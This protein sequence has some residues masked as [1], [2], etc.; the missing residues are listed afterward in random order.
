[1]RENTESG[2]APA[3]KELSADKALLAVLTA[4][5]G[6]PKLSDVVRTISDL[7]STVVIDSFNLSRSQ[8]ATIVTLAGVAPTREDFIMFKSRLEPLLALGTAINYPISDE[9]KTSNVSFSLSFQV[10]EP[11]P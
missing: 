10:V 1:M 11:S 3:A 6:A 5:A 9:L 7:R 4:G 8:T 2:L